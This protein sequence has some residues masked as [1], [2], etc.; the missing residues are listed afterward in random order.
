VTLTVPARYKVGATGKRVGE[1]KSG[2]KTIYRYLADDVHDF[3]WTADPTF[4]V[5]EFRFSPPADIPQGWSALAAKELGMTEAELTL[6]PVDIRLLLSPEHA[7]A[8]DRYVRSTKEALSFFGLWFG[9]HS[10]PTLVDP[11]EDG[12]GAG[13][14]EYPTFF[15][16]LAPSEFLRW[17]LRGVRLVEDVVIH[18]FGHEYWY[19][20]VGSNEFEES[21]LDEGLNSDSEYRA[22]QL[23]Y[24]PRPGQLPGGIGFDMYAFGHGGYVFQPNLDPI[25]RPAWGYFSGGSYGINSYPKV[26]LFLAQLRNDLGAVVFAKAQRAYF[27]E[28]SFR[29]PSTSDFFDVFQ[30]VS[31][32]TSRPTGPTSSRDVA[33]DWSV[34]PRTGTA[35]GTPAWTLGGT[36]TYEGAWCGRRGRGE[37]GRPGEKIYDSVVVF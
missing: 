11:P 25:R 7:A 27:Q 15:T 36:R 32:R 18:E 6:K 26:A 9:A 22:M 10:Y 16:G 1:T 8:R 13:G 4:L 23:A 12:T 24:G 28:W 34:I 3:A 35:G 20:M 2:D 19:G 29:H 5:H 17:P 14:M 33:A 30:R 21:W 31:G 37:E